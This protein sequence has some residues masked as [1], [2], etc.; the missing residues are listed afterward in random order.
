MV[1][2]E[3]KGRDCVEKYGGYSGKVI[4]I[5]LSGERITEYPW[6]DRERERYLGGK[7][8]NQRIMLDLLEGRE[9]AFS[10]ENPILISSGPL[11]G[12]GAPGSNRFDIASLSPRDGAPVFSNGGGN[13]GLQLKK[14]GYDALI[15][16]G[17]CRE[18][19]WLEIHEDQITFHD[20]DFL[21]GS[22]TG[23]CRNM[24]GP[25]YGSRLCIGPAGEN[26]VKFASVTVDGHTAGRAGIGAV[27]GWKN[28]KVITV[29][30][31]REIP[32]RK[33]EA[34]TTLNREWYAS[35]KQH[36]QAKELGRNHCAGCPLHCTRHDRGENPRLN[37]LG[38]DAIAAVDAAAWAMEQGWSVPDIY[39]D[40]AFRRGI[41]DKLA[42][43]TVV[44]RGKGGKRRG[45]SYRAIAE[46][47]GLSP[48]DP[49]TK[50]F[51]RALLEAISASGQCMF[52][53][54]ALHMPVLHTTQM[55]SLVT[56]MEMDLES[57]LQI[58]RRSLELEQELRNRFG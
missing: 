32:V 38:M 31:N 42:E 39:E 26:L 7:I 13:F 57:M 47:F 50:P 58:G 46:A 20:A 1:K 35:L 21:W 11:T 4:Q 51:C 30:G 17:R 8:M 22:E 25:G 15:L 2:T 6:S 18:K 56:G 5:D 3:E 48:D 33:S 43:G 44:S 19:R 16:T 41:G 23:A 12:T 54:N 24:L 49:R 14:A 52:V 55:L 53:A 45:G 34:V 40:I 28:L 29:A 27:M 36:A 10:E 9:A 37:E